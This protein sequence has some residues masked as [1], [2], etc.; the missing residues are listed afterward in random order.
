MMSETTGNDCPSTITK[1]T[2][3][4]QNINTN[5][6]D[7]YVELLRDHGDIVD[8][9]TAGPIAEARRR[10]ARRLVETGCRLPRRGDENY[11]YTS[12]D[13]MFEPD[14]GLN[15]NRVGLRTEVQSIFHCGVPNISSLLGITSN[16]VFS[17]TDTLVSRLPKGVTM[18]AFS[19]AGPAEAEIISR[20]YG[21][22]AAGD[23]AATA[24]N[25]ALAQDGILVHVADG[26]ELE[27]PLQILNILDSL[28]DP[29]QTDK[30]LPVLAARRLLIVMGRRANA[31]LLVCDHDRA[32]DGLSMAD[33]VVEISMAEGSTLNLYELEEGSGT[34]SRLTQ[35]VARQAADSTLNVFVGALKPGTSRNEYTVHLDG[36]GALLNLDG[37]AI[38]DGERVADNCATVLHHA[39]HCTSHQTFKYLVNDSGRGAFEGLIRVDHGAH[40]TEAYQ[41][42]RNMLASPSARM[43]T[44]PQLEIYCDDVKC[45]HGAATGQLDERALFYMRQRGIEYDEARS[46]LMNAF[47]A[48]VLDAIKLEPL[49]DRLRHLVEM[50]ILGDDARCEGCTV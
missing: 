7:Q 31:S 46:M 16:D 43:H 10:T 19:Q 36:P 6:A 30:K 44:Q 38:V 40:A 49:R 23:D 29:A 3:M 15:L 41:N 28:T 9:G 17:P 45:S 48:D 13:K 2:F 33:R 8:R 25:T 27:R 34:T 47:M 18:T 24:L 20:Y 11:E 5:A 32:G 21:T 35:T 42:D 4:N 26:V 22:I 50:R 14:L 39:H 37:M 1:V 12:V